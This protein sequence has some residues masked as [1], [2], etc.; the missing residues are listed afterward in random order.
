MDKQPTWED[1]TNEDG[2]YD[3]AAMPDVVLLGLGDSY[4]DPRIDTVLYE[5]LQLRKAQRDRNT[6]TVT[7]EGVLAKLTHNMELVT[8]VGGTKLMA[9]NR[10]VCHEPCPIHS[11]TDH[12]MVSWRQVW[13]WNPPFDY[14]GIMERLCK[15]GIGHP[16]PDDLHIRLGDDD[17][18]HGC[19]G[20]CLPTV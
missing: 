2:E 7:D 5:Y 3:L 9:H 18:T 12:H 19:D 8:L 11:P 20:C 10:T 15:H 17:G 1:F 16:D 13:R 4:D 6:E 14:R